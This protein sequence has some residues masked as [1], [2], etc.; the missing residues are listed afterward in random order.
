VEKTKFV[1]QANPMLRR[2]WHRC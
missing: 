1:T 2:W